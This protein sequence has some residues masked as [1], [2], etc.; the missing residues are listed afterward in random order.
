VLGISSGFRVRG[1][2]G[3][4]P[5]A[6]LGKNMGAKRSG[7]VLVRRADLRV[8]E[9]LCAVTEALQELFVLL[10]D[11]APVWYTEE[12]HNRALEALER[13]GKLGAR[14]KQCTTR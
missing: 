2:S 12:H 14:Q 6:E 9:Q 4:G 5:A 8:D 10:E 3:T 1:S 11:Y 7:K 13:S